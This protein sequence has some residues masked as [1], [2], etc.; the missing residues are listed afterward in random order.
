MLRIGDFSKLS[1][2][3]IRMLRYYDEM[4]LLKPAVTDPFTA[5]RYYNE[6]QL[7]TIARITALKEMGF[8]L[9]A[10]QELNTRYDSMEALCQALT[11]KRAE[12][13]EQS[14]RMSRQLRLVDTA[15]ERLRKD[16]INMNYSVTVKEI[17]ERTVISVR[18]IIPSYEQEGML[19]G[20]LMSETAALSIQDSDPCYCTATFHDAEY[21]E[22]D[23]DVEVQKTVKG[24]Y[25]NTEN[26]VCKV[27][28]PV[29]VASAICKG[30]YTQ[31][32]EVNQAVASWVRDNGYT[33]AGPMFNIYHVSPYE[34]KDENE[35]VTEVCYPV[36]KL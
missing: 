18:K 9:T 5:Y 8:G 3:S 16:H 22:A 35:Y 29:Q 12:L 10:I 36:A 19:W 11:L 4:G 26:V 15:I 32:D 31:M 25:P 2:V 7:S 33:F 13:M 14:E 27:E 21:K 30:A 1:R 6:A 28:P 23:V 34:T 20:M 24:S 17:P